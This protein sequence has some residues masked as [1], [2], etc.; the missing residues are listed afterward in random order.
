MLLFRAQP[1]EVFHAIVRE[2]LRWLSDD[3]KPAERDPFI[4]TSLLPLTAKRLSV[5]A[6]LATVEELR[7]ALDSS[8]VYEFEPMHRLI[9]AEAL[10]RY[11]E[12]YNDQPQ[13]TEVHLCYEIHQLDYPAMQKVFLDSIESALSEDPAT[14]RKEALQLYIVADAPWRT[15]IPR[16]DSPWYRPD[17][18]YPA[19]SV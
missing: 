3:L 10:Q 4:M 2:A 16:E 15:I 17:R 6:A 18:P 5:G 1:D 7:A 12:A 11:C 8:A 19:L 13:D 14:A 9:V